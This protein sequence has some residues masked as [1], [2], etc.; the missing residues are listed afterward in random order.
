MAEIVVYFSMLIYRQLCQYFHEEMGKKINCFKNCLVGIEAVWSL[1]TAPQKQEI[2]QSSIIIRF[3][4]TDL[5][6]EQCYSCSQCRMES[7]K[8]FHGSEKK[9]RCI[10][11]ATFYISVRYSAICA[12]LV[13]WYVF[14]AMT[15][16]LYMCPKAEIPFNQNAGFCMLI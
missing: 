5:H 11:F 9:Q 16:I 10:W 6:V 4:G 8:D 1:G 7:R 3:F 14:G 12:W 2:R 15:G 13:S